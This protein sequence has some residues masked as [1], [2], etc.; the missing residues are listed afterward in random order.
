MDALEIMGGSWRDEAV[1]LGASRPHIDGFPLEEHQKQTV[2]PSRGVKWK[3]DFVVGT[4]TSQATGPRS[5]ANFFGAR[6][7]AGEPANG[8]TG[9]DWISEARGTT[10]LNADEMGDS[11]PK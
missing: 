10:L 6:G 9:L 2:K 1:L 7:A 8:V 11:E 4:A 5:E 3:E